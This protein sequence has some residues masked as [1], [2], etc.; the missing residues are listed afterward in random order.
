MVV[1]VKEGVRKMFGIIDG[2]IDT[3][4]YLGCLFVASEVVKQL[5]IGRLFPQ[6]TSLIGFLLSI[7]LGALIYSPISY[8]VSRS[9]SFLTRYSGESILVT[10]FDIVLGLTFLIGLLML[11]NNWKRR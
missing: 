2:I 5:N 8:G 3:A 11:Y 9:L 4:L 1:G 6:N 10:A 7:A